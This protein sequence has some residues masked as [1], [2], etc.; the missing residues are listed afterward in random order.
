VNS[1]FRFKAKIEVVES[2]ASTQDEAKRWLR[3]NP[4]SHFDEAFWIRALHQSAGRGRQGRRWEDSSKGSLLVSVGL[5]LPL[6]VSAE[7]LQRSL[8]TLIAGQALYLSVREMGV[9]SP[10]LFLKWPNDLVF[11]GEA[12]EPG[13][14]GSKNSMSF[15]K[16]AGILAESQGPTGIVV[17]WG[18]NVTRSPELS[19]AGALSDLLAQA[20]LDD[21]L[22]FTKLRTHFVRLVLEWLK[23]PRNFSASL[24]SQLENESMRPLWGFEGWWGAHRA[25]ALGL[26]ASTG[27]LRIEISEPGPR[28]G[29][30]LSVSSGEFV[31]DRQKVATKPT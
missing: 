22:L 16:V 10:R 26:D 19:V 11:T 8:V 3:E 4:S 5:H 9:L 7:T 30:I 18:V 2:V 29:E 12:Q 15:L 13:G 17:G 24:I 27:A 20:R 28:R 1:P 14:R 6:H 23:D 31:F 25:K 21:E